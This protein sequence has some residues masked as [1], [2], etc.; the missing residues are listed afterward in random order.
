MWLFRSF[1]PT[2]FYDAYVICVWALLTTPF[3][4]I[5]N[6]NG[7]LATFTVNCLLLSAC[8][9]SL[10]LYPIMSNCYVIYTFIFLQLEVLKL[11][12]HP[13]LLRFY[14]TVIEPPTFCIVT[15]YSLLLSVNFTVIST[16]KFCL[17]ALNYFQSVFAKSTFWLV[18]SLQS[19][20]NKEPSLIF[21]IR[22]ILT[23]IETSSGQDRLLL[24]ST[25]MWIS[26]ELLWWR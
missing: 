20:W 3:L 16:F 11:V 1:L 21:F 19:M 17:C 23:L 5:L 7:L 13:N 18:Y 6:C 25:F 22:M 24:V 4:L 8:L 12:N 14:G 9:L 10:I 26:L 2:N 15:G